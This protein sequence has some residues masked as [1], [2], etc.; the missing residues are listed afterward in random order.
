VEQPQPLEHPLL[1]GHITLEA[2]DRIKHLGT[3][4]ADVEAGRHAQVVGQMPAVQQRDGKAGIQR[5]AL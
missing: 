3:D 2:S 4:T 1:A 5:L